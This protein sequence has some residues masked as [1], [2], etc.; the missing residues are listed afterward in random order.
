MAD[1]MIG[2]ECKQCGYKWVPRVPDPKVCPGCKRRNW[3][4]PK[5]E[6]RNVKTT[7]QSTQSV[8]NSIERRT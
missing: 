7:G 4:G 2:L 8:T 5:R 3:D 6:G 1:A